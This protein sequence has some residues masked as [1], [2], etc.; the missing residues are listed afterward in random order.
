MSKATVKGA[1]SRSA[2][3]LRE[4]KRAERATYENETRVGICSAKATPIAR[5]ITSW[6]LCET[7][8]QEKDT[9]SGKV[10]PLTSEGRSNEPKEADEEVRDRD[11]RRPA[12]RRKRTCR[13]MS[14][15]RTARSTPSCKCG[16]GGRTEEGQLRAEPSRTRAR[17][18]LARPIGGR[19]RRP[20]DS[21][22]STR[23][24]KSVCAT[25]AKETGW[26]RTES[27][28]EA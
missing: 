23:W 1:A 2:W 4:I 27:P 24:H 3:P 13:A 12:Q 10:D 19:W 8:A 25:G 9:R 14:A 16:R 26:G 20:A 21:K 28:A 11:H 17:T 18:S 22:T 5:K 15:V 6:T 7:K